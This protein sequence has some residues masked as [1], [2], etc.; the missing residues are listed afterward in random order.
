MILVRAI[1]NWEVEEQM[2]LGIDSVGSCDLL[3]GNVEANVG[4]KC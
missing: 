3:M 1:L 2:L 4:A